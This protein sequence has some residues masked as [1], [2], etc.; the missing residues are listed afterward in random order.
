MPIFGRKFFFFL[1][2]DHDDDL[3]Y[4]SNNRNNNPI[5]MMIEYENRIQKREKWEKKK[6][7]SEPRKKIFSQAIE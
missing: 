1:A 4:C 5:K 6:I 2:F 3:L 7:L